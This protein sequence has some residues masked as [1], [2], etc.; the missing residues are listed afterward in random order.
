MRFQNVR[1]FVRQFSSVVLGALSCHVLVA[2]HMTGPQVAEPKPT[3]VVLKGL[4]ADQM[5]DGWQCNSSLP[6]GEITDQRNGFVMWK[7]GAFD[8]KEPGD[9]TFYLFAASRENAKCRFFIVGDEETK[10][11]Y[12][13]LISSIDYGIYGE[14]SEIIGEMSIRKRSVCPSRPNVGEIDLSPDPCLIKADESLWGSISQIWSNRSSGT[15][16][17]NRDVETYLITSDGIINTKGEKM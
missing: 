13:P 12:E 15:H 11:F 9:A 3:A 10:K 8:A 17:E 2:C 14:F 4:T 5:P 16:G 1:N 6:I 7:I